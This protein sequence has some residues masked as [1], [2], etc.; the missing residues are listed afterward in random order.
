M[1]YNEL[2]KNFERI[3]EYMK[4]FYVYGFKSRDE[5]GQSGRS[6]DDERRRIESYLGDYMSF[7]Q[8]KSGKNVFISIDSRSTRQNPL[9]SAWKTKS[10]TDGD[11]T[12]HFIIFDILFSSDIKMTLNEITD[13]IYSDYL[14]AFENPIQLDESTIRKKLKEYIGLGLL[15]EQKIG[16]KSFYSRTESI[17]LSN[18]KDALIFFSE[19]CLCGVVG[20]FL[21]DRYDFKNN[22]FSFKHNYITHTLDSEI[23]CSLFE[24]VHEKCSVEFTYYL[25]K[26]NLKEIVEIVPLKIFVS[27]Q[28]GRCCLFGYNKKT[29]LI[30]SFRLDY[31]SKVHICEK[32]DIFDD[33]QEKLKEMQPNLWGVSAKGTRKTEHV[34]FTVHIN[35]DEEYIYK[36]LLR[37]KR[38]GSVE[39][40]DK[41]TCRFTADVYDSG[42]LVPWIRTF[43]CRIKSMDF[44][45]RTVE[46]RIKGEL[47]EMYKMYGLG[48]D[49]N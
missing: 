4:E 5:Y 43:I 6:Y 30:K 14:S 41:N 16:R 35:D 13:K 29:K 18:C 3:R 34:E 28:N 22:I 2:V 45:N 40:L 21:L 42:E 47:E 20:S 9:Y 46:N 7:R 26:R 10:F 11:I 12:F 1:A 32:C 38:C 44:S 23:I 8:T 37:E 25:R 19:I 27:V 24:A 39:M 33:L 48:D 36:R 49:R 15:N 31:I 17:D